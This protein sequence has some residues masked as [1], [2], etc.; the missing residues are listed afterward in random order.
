VSD[1]LLQLVPLRPL[2]LQESTQGPGI[3]RAQGSRSSMVRLCYGTS[4]PL[5]N[6][7]YRFLSSYYRRG[8]L[9]VSLYARIVEGT[10]NHYM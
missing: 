5:S 2:L 6:P 3:Y 9:Q 4:L 10:S 1:V 8:K 7:L